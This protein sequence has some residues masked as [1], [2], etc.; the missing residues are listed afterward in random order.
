MTMF[1]GIATLMVLAGLALVLPPLL[2]RRNGREEATPEAANLAIYRE[3]LADLEAD[4][5]NGN[6]DRAEYEEAHRELEQGVLA[7]AGDA[8]TG[9]ASGR[10]QPARITSVVVAVAMP[11]VAVALYLY[12]G[13]G[14]RPETAPPAAGGAGGAMPSPQAMVAR[15]EARLQADPDN[16]RGWRMLGRSY[17]VLERYPEAVKALG[18]AREL[19]GDDAPLLTQ[20]AEALAM[21]RGAD[22]TGEPQRLLEQALALQPRFPEALWL[23]GYAAFQGGQHERAIRHWEKLL[24]QYPEDGEGAQL[25]RRHLEMARQRL[26]GGRA[27]NPAQ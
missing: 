17:L 23:A 27:P 20:Y 14:E 11:A 16:V 21:T 2:L 13:V 4:L 12:L 19:A 8:G 3:R 25:I 24:S 22:L 7:D 26:D 18:R 6:L 5:A 9:G 10:H 15:L 1:W